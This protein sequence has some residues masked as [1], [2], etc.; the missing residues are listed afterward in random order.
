MRFYRVDGLASEGGVRGGNPA[1]IVLAED[2]RRGADSLE[3]RLRAAEA[4]GF[5]ETVFAEKVERTVN[6]DNRAQVTL[7]GAHKRRGG[8]GARR[9]QPVRRT[10]GGDAAD[11]C[12]R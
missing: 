12:A 4:I 5:S 3:R 1:A 7:A 9:R 8:R 10:A 2:A 6:D 11:C